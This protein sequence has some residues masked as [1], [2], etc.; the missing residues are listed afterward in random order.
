VPC[1][2]REQPVQIDQDSPRVRFPPPL[3]YLGALLLGIAADRFIAGRSGLA[4]LHGLGLADDVRIWIAVA[5]LATGLVIGLLAAGLFRRAGTDVKPW[6]SSTALV[7]DGPYRWT[8]N[9]MYLG[10]TFVYLGLAIAADS[11]TALVLLI[12]VLIIIQTQVIAREERYLESKFGDEFRA[13]TARVR[14]WL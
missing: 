6:R 4:R 8:R 13:Y 7:T 2:R 11:L 10:M 14:R 3:I 12:P 5:V 1:A 9:P